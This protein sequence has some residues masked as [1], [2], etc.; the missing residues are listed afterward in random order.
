M[1][2]RRDNT[3]WLILTRLPDEQNFGF[4]GTMTAEGFQVSQ[5]NNGSSAWRACLKVSDYIIKLNF[6]PKRLDVRGANRSWDGNSMDVVNT[7]RRVILEIQVRTV[8]TER[9]D[10]NFLGRQS[11]FAGVMR[12]MTVRTANM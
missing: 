9:Q 6:H 4:D 10:S 12:R 1:S 7:S 5:V 3:T 11:Y 8:G 2:T